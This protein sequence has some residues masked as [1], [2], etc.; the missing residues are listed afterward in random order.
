M[1]WEQDA[2]PE[3]LG[4]R[5]TAVGDGARANGYDA[6]AVGQGARATGDET[7]AVGQTF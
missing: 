7:V 4:F 3:S 2:E 1:C 5:T 6:T